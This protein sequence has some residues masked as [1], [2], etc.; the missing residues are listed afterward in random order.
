MTSSQAVVSSD[1]SDTH[2]QSGIAASK[3][4]PEA[5]EP[6]LRAGDA[7]GDC[8]GAPEPE[9]MPNAGHSDCAP[10]G[11]AALLGS[12][13]GSM[14]LCGPPLAKLSP[15]SIRQQH[16]EPNIKLAPQPVPSGLLWAPPLADLSPPVITVEH[17]EPRL[18]SPS[19]KCPPCYCGAR[20]C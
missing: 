4:S 8:G 5:A 7:A 10:K 18:F 19:S 17:L 14:L 16:P 13:M 1:S 20:H 9:L 12:R 3:I 11:F 15:A 2:R 6:V